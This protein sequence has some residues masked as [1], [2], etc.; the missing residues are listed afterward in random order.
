MARD[1]PQ[2]T[3]VTE[4]LLERSEQLA[5]L[6]EAY[7]ATQRDRRGR[8]VL[9]S[10]EAGIGKTTLLRAFA[11]EHPAARVLAGACDA[12]HTPR[13][14]GPFA[15]IAEQ[16]G[17]DLADLVAE[18]A[19]PAQVVHALAGTLPADASRRTVLVLE[20]LHWA[21]SATLDVLRLLARK[22]HDLPVLVL[23]TYRDDELDRTHPLRIAL[24]EL[25]RE[26][27]T[28]IALP[29]LSPAAV[30]TLVGD[31]DD[32]DCRD[33]HERTA[34][35]PFFVT[36]I[37]AMCD[38]T[39]PA[40]VRDA[41]LARAAR[42]DPPAQRVLDA[43]AVVPH[44]AELWL[45]EA[46]TGHDLDG[47]DA[48]IASGM[49]RAERATIS[50]R[51]EIARVAIEESLA[52]HSRAQLHA[53][54]LAALANPRHGQPDPARLA[55]HA[56]AAGDAH[57]VLAHA[58]AAG[59]RA[60][61][62]GSHKEAADQFE[63]A[64]RYADGVDPTTRADLLERLSY[65][66]YLVSCIGDAVEARRLALAEHERTK[67]TRRQGDAHRWLSRLAWY[68]GD[69]AVAD[70]EAAR[71]VELLEAHPPGRELAMAYSNLAQ[72]RM[73]ASDLPGATCWGAEAIA[74]AEELDETEILVHALN[75]V[76]S[77]E[78]V[79]GDETGLAKLERSLALALEAGLDEHVGRAYTN[80][81][82]IT[83]EARDLALAEA[84]LMA[85]IA[86]CTERDLDA[87]R[88]YMTGYRA[89]VELDRGRLDDARRSAE[90]VLEHPGVTPPTRIT[91]LVVLGRIAARTGADPWPVLDEAK[92]LA[93]RTGE[94]Q[95]L[96]AVAIARAEARWLA[97]EPEAIDDETADVLRAAIAS[98][99]DAWVVGELALWRR[100]A[101]LLDA[102][103]PAEGPMTPFH[104]ELARRHEEAARHWTVIGCRYEAAL[105]RAH[106]P[107]EDEQRGA[108][109]ELLALGATPA[110]QR[111]ARTL[112]ER[113][114]RGLR[115]GPRAK[116]RANP[117]GMTAR[118]L[119]VLS[120]VAEGLRNADIA[121]RLFLSE[122]TVA[123]HVSAILRKLDVPSRGQAGV[124]AA[125]LG[126]VER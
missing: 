112:R 20:D 106:A 75:N 119:E 79:R 73:L 50:F 86:Y 76:G 21:D 65:E 39:V 126:L 34:G 111:V 95:R 77:A 29:A 90:S 46:I 33:L 37:L 88:I 15:D 8:L 93:T 92:E 14:L 48:G 24:G 94:L 44:A 101:G 103:L 23:A 120:H 102:D 99:H 80:L 13:P 61:R 123:H 98:E 97:G 114:V 9:L 4:G 81:A 110:A 53:R 89:R 57:A 36:E 109:E 72:L 83:A 68:S 63:R 100:R 40:T 11:A 41:V 25:P 118:E 45:L 6:A 91:P 49:L 32:Y 105:A 2:T 58:P 38:G 3:V 42:L 121:A 113:G 12:L 35:N 67:D 82:S 71:A 5:A 115:H 74:L 108:L 66:C 10:G 60:A 104:L 19:T 28:R 69:N 16:A 43:V 31:T 27:A 17:G 7:A 18:Q 56:E 107:G 125:R 26:R 54:A 1:A 64:L 96:S 22:L 51:H 47:L 62:L 117:A 59:E 52:P 55:H 30:A 87:W 84:Y 124:A 122:K 116:T 70:E 78:L 85:G